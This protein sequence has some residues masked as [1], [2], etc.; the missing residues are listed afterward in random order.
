M[1]DLISLEEMDVQRENDG[2]EDL[3]SGIRNEFEKSVKDGKKPLFMTNAD[4]LYDL[5]LENIPEEARQHYNCNACRHFVNRF[6]GLVTINEKT[7]EQ[8]PVMWGTKAPDFF[9]SSVKTLRKKVKNAKVTGVFITSDRR[10]GT[11]VTGSWHHMATDM[12]KI[13]IFKDRLRTAG[14]AAAEKLEDR[15]L[16]GDAVGKYKVETVETAVN[17]LRSDNLYRSEAVLGV[18]EW[19]LDTLRG[20]KKAKNS[21]NF[22]W[23]K[24]ATAPVGFCHI[25]TSMI[26]TLLDDIEAGYDFDTVSRKFAEKMDPLKYQ[27]PQAAPSAGNVAQAEKIVERLGI[28]N[29]LKRRFARLDELET[30]WTP[31]KMTVRAG[32]PG[33]VFSGI[34]TK[35][36]T[37][38]T[39]EGI[40]APAVTMTWEK[41][42]RTVL[43]TARKIEFYVTGG[44]DNFSAILTAED[45]D[46]PPIL[47]W[48]TEERRIPF[49]WY[50]YSGGS[51]PRRWNLSAGYVDVT[52]VVLQPNMWVD[53]FERKSKSVFF[54]LKGAKDTQYQGSGIA[55]FPETLKAELREIRSTIEAYSKRSVLG[56][57]DEA[58][59]CGIRLQGGSKWNA[60][61]R[62]TT[63]VG[64][65][66]Y[67]LDRWD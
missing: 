23:Y 61:F 47:Q 49:S 7:G 12:P 6:G 19:F 55:L 39:T 17:L 2:Y 28:E 65:T 41:F 33:G 63:D 40:S 25:S 56:G 53:G 64:T 3:L 60:R 32:K 35:E 31:K 20:M 34:E 30:L 15:R 5:F 29:S 38:R 57:Y 10:L 21:G 1:K 24:T 44:S 52:G 9:A 42:R 11:P 50:V 67:I 37:K 8:T 54:I 26:G 14:Q 18:A 22:L 46:A 58:S 4:G 59:A 27:R 48:D 45:F 36:S 51:Y 43:P 62:V 16:L 66:C 13:M